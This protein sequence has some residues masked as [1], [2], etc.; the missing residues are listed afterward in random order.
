MIAQPASHLQ[1][2]YLPIR[3]LRVR[4]WLRRSEPGG[5]PV[6][7]PISVD[8]IDTQTEWRTLAAMQHQSRRGIV[9]AKETF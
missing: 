4:I 1:R 9:P 2:T 7:Q 5:E 6:Q 3:G 8:P